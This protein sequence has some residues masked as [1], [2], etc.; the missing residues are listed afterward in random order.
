MYGIRSSGAPLI[1][2]TE[3]DPP[4]LRGLGP[5]GACSHKECRMLHLHKPTDAGWFGRIE[6]H[7]DTILLDH[8]HL[9]K[10]AASAAMSMMFRYTD[11]PELAKLL[12]EVVHEELDHFTQMLDILAERGVAYEPIEPASYAARL[13]RQTAKKDPDALLDKLLVSSLIEARSCERFQVLAENVDDVEL[14]DFYADLMVSEAR[15]H[16]LYTNLAREM[17]DA[18][19]VRSRLDELAKLEWRALSEATEAPRLHS[20]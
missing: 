18:E 7:L 9:E 5:K 14:R 15:H 10:R 20:F 3:A 12:A 2:T 13:M 1:A 19:T 4:Q 16:T 8:T 6:P 11:K 17:F